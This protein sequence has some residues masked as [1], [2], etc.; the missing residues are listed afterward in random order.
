MRLPAT[1]RK[2]GNSSS[3]SLSKRAAGAITVVMPK[4]LNSRTPLRPI[5]ASCRCVGSARRALIRFIAC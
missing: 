3:A 5:A 1:F 2:A 4:C